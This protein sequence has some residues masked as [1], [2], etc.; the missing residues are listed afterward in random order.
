VL[1]PDYVT[2]YIIGLMWPM[3]I[4]GGRDLTQGAETPRAG[5]VAT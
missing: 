4:C 1:I 2:R 5:R 3:Q